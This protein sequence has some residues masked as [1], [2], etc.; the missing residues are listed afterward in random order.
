MT[1]ITGLK[2]G[3]RMLAYV[4]DE[5]VVDYVARNVRAG[6]ACT[7]ERAI[8]NYAPDWPGPAE[9]E[10]RT[11]SPADEDPQFDIEMARAESLSER[12]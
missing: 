9:S 4:P 1:R 12:V 6:W 7:I 3:R 5:W 8:P 2:N 11:E 10:N